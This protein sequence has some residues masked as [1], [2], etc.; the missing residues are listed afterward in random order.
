MKKKIVSAV[1]LSAVFLVPAHSATIDL[2]QAGWTTYGDGN[3]ISLP[4]S[5]LSVGSG[6]GQIAMFTRLGLG[7][8][9]QLDNAPG[10]DEAFDTPQANNISGFR[11]GAGNEPVTTGTWDRVGWWDSSLA[12][13]NSALNLLTNSMVFFF[14]NNETGGADTA[15]LA[16]WSRIEV[17]R[18]SDNALLGR[19]DLTNQGGGYGTPI[20]SGLG[21]GAPLGGGVVLGDV[22]DYTSTGAAPTVGDF[23][24]SGSDVCVY[25]G[26]PNIGLPTA[27]PSVSDPNITKYAH[28]LGGDHAA[29]A[30]VFPELDAL[31][32]SLVQGGNLTDYAVHVDYR[33]G[34]GL[35]GAFPT[36]RQG[37]NLECNGD[38]ALNGGDEKL[39]LGTQALTTTRVPEPSAIMLLALGLLSLT[40]M[41]RN[42]RR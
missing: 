3:A 2:S 4:A 12:A 39:F 29:Y 13:L 1:V 40:F 33:L 20:T 24:R 21:I 7:A 34:C 6:P 38:Y 18:I 9:G 11:M 14:A 8:N 23:L 30:V 19:Y 15:N 41:R 35:E 36:V 5:N 25:T 10:M 42:A 37:N 26:G 16:A 22:T 31:I 27:C 17:T 32:F 28:N